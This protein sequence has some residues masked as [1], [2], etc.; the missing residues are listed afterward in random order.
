M[1]YT[2]ADSARQGKSNEELLN[3]WYTSVEGVRYVYGNRRGGREM[4]EGQG[5]GKDDSPQPSN[6]TPPVTWPVKIH[7]EIMWEAERDSG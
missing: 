2:S 6:P 4:G 3:E 1:C 5:D 7:E